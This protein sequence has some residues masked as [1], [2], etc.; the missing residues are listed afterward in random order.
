MDRRKLC[1]G[2]RPLSR[3]GVAAKSLF[4]LIPSFLKEPI[5]RYLQKKTGTFTDFILSRKGFFQ[6]LNDGHYR[7]LRRK[8]ER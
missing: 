7:S 8:A 2:G 5:V 3:A 1:R 6:A 4:S